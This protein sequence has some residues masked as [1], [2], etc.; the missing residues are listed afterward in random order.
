MSGFKFGAYG[1]SL[2]M[3]TNI[4]GGGG[5]GGGVLLRL[6]LLSAI[7]RLHD[8]RACSQNMVLQQSEHFKP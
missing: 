4:T 8:S 1:S 7:Y 3:Q 2:P 6:L 5:E